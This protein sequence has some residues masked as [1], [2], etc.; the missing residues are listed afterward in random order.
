MLENEFKFKIIYE[1]GM[2]EVYQGHVGRKVD[3][4]TLAVEP[5]RYRLPSTG[6]P[7]EIS[8]DLEE[9]HYKIKLLGCDVEKMPAVKKS[10]QICRNK[11]EHLVK[12]YLR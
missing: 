4:P 12:S 6:E 10:A 5:L 11:E 3:K 7:V 1:G 8:W 9:E 2:E